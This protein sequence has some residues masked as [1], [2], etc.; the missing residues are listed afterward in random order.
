MWFV[1]LFFLLASATLTQTT[2][3]CVLSGSFT[4]TSPGA[5]FDN[6]QRGCYNWRFTYVSSGF[7][8]PTFIQVEGSPTGAFPWAVLPVVT[9][10]GLNPSGSIT[11]PITYATAGF[12]VAPSF[13]RV[14]LVEST[15]TGGVGGLIQ[16]Q[17]IG[18]AG[19]AASN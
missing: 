6:R 19:A 16:F 9:G 15:T 2:N 13:I 12:H 17:L 14:N 10:D 11:A 8:A 4:D 3:Q 7:I 5:S 1:C 18:T